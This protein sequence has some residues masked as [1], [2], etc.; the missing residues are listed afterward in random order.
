MYVIISHNLPCLTRY[1]MG[2][3]YWAGYIMSHFSSGLVPEIM[4]PPC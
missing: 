3:L 4:K 2:Y 1:Y